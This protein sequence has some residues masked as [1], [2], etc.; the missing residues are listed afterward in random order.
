MN[1]CDDELSVDVV[2]R[3]KLQILSQTCVL[4]IAMSILLFRF[5]IV[6]TY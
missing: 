6:S 4:R 5:C 1:Q 3:I 2:L